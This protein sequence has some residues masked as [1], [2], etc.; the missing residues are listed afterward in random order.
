M[1]QNEQAF[2]L[3]DNYDL[4]GTNL[5]TLSLSDVR[6]LQNCM[7][8]CQ[9]E[10]HCQGYTYNKFFRSCSFKKTV[11]TLRFDPSSV[12]GVSGSLP[13]ASDAPF[14]MELIEE[15]RFVGNSYRSQAISS[16]AECE[17][18]CEEDQQCVGT[19]YAV[20]Q[21]TCRLFGTV[22]KIVTDAGTASAMKRRIAQ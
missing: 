17:R 2:T 3:Y 4:T 12:A 7:E 8:A 20:T 14:E 1:A 6:D 5:S 9:I 15:R 19:S 16:Y 21:H 18:I 22:A 10:A 13:P 11:G